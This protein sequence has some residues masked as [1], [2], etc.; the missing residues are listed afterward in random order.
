[1]IWFACKQCGRKQ[2][3]PDSAAGSLVFCECGQ[4]NRVPWESTVEAPEAPPEPEPSSPYPRRRPRFGDFDEPE[5]PIRRRWR[6]PEARD[7][8]YCFNHQ[9]VA[10]E[11][12]CS[13]CGEHF[14]PNCVVAFRGQTLCGPC[15]NFR[16]AGVH[17]PLS[18]SVMAIVS[19]VLAGIGLPLGFCLSVSGLVSMSAPSPLVSLFLH[20][21]GLV[22]PGVAFVLGL[23]AMREIDRNPRVGGRGLA[24]TGAAAA[25]VGVIWS[26]S[27]LV[28]T[29]GRQFVD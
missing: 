15:K 18:I 10:Y 1:M 28:V 27:L 8:A 25:V 26:V 23:L 12:V 4:G 3:R 29:A 7:P 24:I 5:R 13:D 21:L 16:V 11:Q 2:Q 9:Q 22:V 19:L 6:E 20:A 14:C 17:R